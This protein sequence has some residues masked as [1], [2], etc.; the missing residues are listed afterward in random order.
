M[1]PKSRARR[2]AVAFRYPACAGN[3]CGRVRH[4]VFLAV[5]TRQLQPV[6]ARLVASYRAYC[7]ADDVNNSRWS[8]DARNVIDSMRLYR[9]LHAIRHVALRLTDDHSIVFGNQKPA[10]NVLPKWVPDRNSDAAQRYR[11]LHGSEHGSLVRGRALRER[12]F[13]G[14]IG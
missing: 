13:E 8:G 14:S 7:V 2:S 10:R 12:R 4:V 6:R 3:D 9:R 5:L 1:A 11:P